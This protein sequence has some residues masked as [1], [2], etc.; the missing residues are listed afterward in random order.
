MAASPECGDLYERLMHINREAFDGAHYDTAYHALAAALHFAQDQRDEG[1][2]S[3]VARIAS[4]QIT[5]IDRHTPAYHHS[6]TSAVARGND[7]I[8]AMLSRQAHT[9]A[10][11]LR[12]ERERGR[13]AREPSR[14][15]DDAAAGATRAAGEDPPPGMGL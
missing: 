5:W 14:P 9:R 1:R 11:I 13:E 15:G 2:L 4:E 8:Y 10:Q 3:A 6:T 12:Q 7:S